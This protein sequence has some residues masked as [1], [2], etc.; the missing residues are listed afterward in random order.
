[1]CHRKAPMPEDLTI[2]KAIETLSQRENELWRHDDQGVASALI[3]ALREM[4]NTRVQ[5][6]QIAVAIADI[7]SRISEIIAKQPQPVSRPES[8]DGFPG[9]PAE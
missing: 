2:D 8:K 9:Y 7:R 1:M 6:L 5:I 3:L 4:A